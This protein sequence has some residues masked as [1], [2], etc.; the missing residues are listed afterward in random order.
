MSSKS[1]TRILR[2]K[3]DQPKKPKMKPRG[4]PSAIKPYQFKK[5]NRYQKPRQKAKHDLIASA[6]RVELD[7]VVPP[8]VSAA[9]G[10]N[11]DATWAEAIAFAMIRRAAT[12]DAMA[13]KEIREV[14]EGRLPYSLSAGPPDPVINYSLGR[15]PRQAL[16]AKLVGRGDE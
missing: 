10:M 5:G 15:S 12:G 16:I 3:I 2:L 13:A 14:T 8:E 11:G 7:S 6:Y 1:S 4:D 9:L